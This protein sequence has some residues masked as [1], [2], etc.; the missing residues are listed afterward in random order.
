MNFHFCSSKVGIGIGMYNIIYVSVIWYFFFLSVSLSTFEYCRAFFIMRILYMY[1]PAE[2]Y[3]CAYNVYDMIYN[4]VSP[5]RTR[6][7]SNAIGKPIFYFGDH[8]HYYCPILFFD[9]TVLRSSQS[10]HK[11]RSIY[12]YIPIYI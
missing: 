4:I 5:K 1:R 8:Y 12:A 7:D 11:Y 9:T 6:R 10:V 2:S 3:G